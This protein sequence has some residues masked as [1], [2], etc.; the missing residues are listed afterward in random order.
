MDDSL[1]LEGLI[2]TMSPLASSYTSLHC[3]TNCG[4]VSNTD[5]MTVDPAALI[6][7]SRLDW[8]RRR[9]WCWLVPAVYEL[10]S[11][12]NPEPTYLRKSCHIVAYVSYIAPRR[13]QVF[14][15]IVHGYANFNGCSRNACDSCDKLK[16]GHFI[17]ST[18]SDSICQWRRKQSHLQTARL[19]ITGRLG[20][21]QLKARG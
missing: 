15:Q 20:G 5:W 6:L 2:A 4:R 13:P 8:T 12:F 11:N 3:S 7:S 14:G 17:W 21:V 10:R 16:T 1:P 19:K 18:T 9:T